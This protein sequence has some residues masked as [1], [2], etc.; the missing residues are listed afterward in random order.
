MY[1]LK[2]S[3]VRTD[4]AGW[5]ESQASDQAAAQVRKNISVQVLHYHNIKLIRIHDKLHAGVIDDFIITFNLR[6]FLCNLF[7]NGK[8]H[9]IGHFQDIC[10]MNTG[11]FL[12]SVLFRILECIA[13]NAL[14]CLSCNNL[15]CMNC[16]R[17][18]LLLYTNIKTFC[19]F[20]ENHNIHIL[21]WSFY[22]RVGLNRAD[23]GIQ[24]ILS[25]KC[26]IQG[27]ESFSNRSRNRGF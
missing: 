9:A 23:I 2:H 17:I 20:A 11:Y 19:I 4:I 27:A 14:A 13:D 6:I 26:Y 25:A 16:I 12:A 18:Y 21:K 1:G 3:I 10:L 5:N 24:V 22:C 15:N 7:E 8:E